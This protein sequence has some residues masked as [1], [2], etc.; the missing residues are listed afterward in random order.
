M[1]GSYKIRRQ[2]HFYKV[3]TYIVIVI[4]RVYNF[5]AV[6]DWTID[7]ESFGYWVAV[8]ISFDVIFFA[9]VIRQQTKFYFNYS[10]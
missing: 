9:W 8:F 6:Y 3:S 4:F 2:G 7:K 5:L 1:N 10:K